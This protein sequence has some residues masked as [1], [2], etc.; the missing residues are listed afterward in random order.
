MKLIVFSDTHGV[1]YAM[2]DAMQR[3]P[4]ADCFLHL[5]DGAPDFVNLC[6]ARGLPYAAVRGNCDFA[7][8]LP[9]EMTLS[10]GDYTFYLTH[11]HSCQVKYTTASIR[12]R[13]MAAGADVI[14]FGHTHEPLLQYFSD[15]GERPYY[16]FNPGSAK[17]S[18]GAGA[19]YGVIEIKGK[20]LL[21][22]HANVM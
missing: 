22:N 10:F 19:T 4:N 14:L 16:L 6:R 12:S 18:Y 7:A 1:N 5:G 15:D 17:R 20:N 9:L 11:G 21:I 2:L 3:H 8:D 13:G